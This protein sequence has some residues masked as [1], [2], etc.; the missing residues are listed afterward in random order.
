MVHYHAVLDALA[1]NNNLIDNSNS[2]DPCDRG[3][4]CKAMLAFIKTS[5]SQVSF[6]KKNFSIYGK[7][8][9]G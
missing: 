7:G 9:S 5:L 1:D 4:T 6:N 2:I 3:K 8:E